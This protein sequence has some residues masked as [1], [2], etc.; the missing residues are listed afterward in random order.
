MHGFVLY[1]QHGIVFISPKLGN[2]ANA[3]IKHIHIQAG[4]FHLFV[5]T[6]KKIVHKV[7]LVGVYIDLDLSFPSCQYF[8]FH[9]S[10]LVSALDFS[11]E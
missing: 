3:A 9:I 2:K 10:T 11:S 4:V 5:S 1:L 8:P 7:K 6:R